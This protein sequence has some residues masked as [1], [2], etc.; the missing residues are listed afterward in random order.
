MSATGG[1]LSA[2]VGGAEELA[3]LLV[4]LEAEPSLAADLPRY[5]G[6]AGKTGLLGKVG[7]FK[8][9]AGK[10]LPEE[11]YTAL[12]RAVPQLNKREKA[13]CHLYI[14]PERVKLPPRIELERSEAPSRGSWLPSRGYSCS[15]ERR[16]MPSVQR[17]SGQR[18]A[19]SR[20]HGAK[21]ASGGGWCHCRW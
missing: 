6:T 11:I 14:S 18:G 21:V 7:L 5:S 13:G 3:P 20:G 19:S 15:N 16:W 2:V 12:G 4:L 1:L 8:G 17:G 9:K 10:G